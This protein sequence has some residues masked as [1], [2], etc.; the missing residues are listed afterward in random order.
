MWQFQWM[1]SLIPDSMLFWIYSTF[2]GAGL[3]LYFGSMLFKYFPFKYIP[4]VGQYP[5]ISKF[6]GIV[7][8]VLGVYLF[9][10]YGVEMS[11]R[12]KVH[13][14]EEKVK[15]SERKSAEANVKLDSVI[16]EKNR[17]VKDNLA[18]LQS[19]IKFNAAKIDAE[20][21]VPREAITILNKAA[22]TPK[23]NK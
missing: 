15:E 13:Q 5:M 3:I 6:F 9:G 1:L 2:L 14:L 8:T 20:C 17:V 11:W 4:L 19:Q 22:E 21:K 18:N 10:G 23:R 16:K 12:D 7:F